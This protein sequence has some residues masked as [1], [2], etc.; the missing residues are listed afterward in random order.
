MPAAAIVGGSVISG[1]LGASAANKASKAQQNSANAATAEQK[2]QFDISN[3][4]MQP[5]LQSGQQG[6]NDLNA[7]SN[8]DSSKFFTD[9]GYQFALSEGQRG[10]GSSFAARGG[11]A[12]GNALKAL[13]QFNQGLAS[14]QY[15]DYYNRTAARAGMGQQTVNSLANLGQ[16]YA[17]NAGQTMMASGDARASGIIGSANSLSQGI[18]G[19]LNSYQYFKAPQPMS[20][21]GNMGSYDPNKRWA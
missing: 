4:N 14:Q 16:N 12:S 19:G 3:A 20:G 17:N 7:L 21:F 8:G 9:P 5:W 13:S 18:A 15:G 2:R 6:L 10:V 1:V 11:A